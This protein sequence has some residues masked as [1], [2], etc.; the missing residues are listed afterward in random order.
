MLREVKGESPVSKL[1]QSFRKNVG[2]RRKADE[3]RDL[4]VVSVVLD[5]LFAVSCMGEGRVKD[6]GHALDLAG[7][8]LLR[9]QRE[10]QPERGGVV[11]VCPE[12]A[13]V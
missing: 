7:Q 2:C 9:P 4:D 1:L 3:L 12:E 11:Q 5:D 10:E 13:Q 6:G 8:G